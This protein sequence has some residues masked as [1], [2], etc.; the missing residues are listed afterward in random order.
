M[1]NYFLM[2]SLEKKISGMKLFGGA[3]TAT[4]MATV[5]ELYMTPYIITLRVRMVSINLYMYLEQKKKLQKN[6]QTFAR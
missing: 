6:T 5:L 1:L 4:M 3:H 2:T